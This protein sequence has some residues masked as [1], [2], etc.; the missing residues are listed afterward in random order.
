MLEKIELAFNKVAI[1]TIIVF[2][3]IANALY[4]QIGA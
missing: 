3:V 4:I 1:P 2:T